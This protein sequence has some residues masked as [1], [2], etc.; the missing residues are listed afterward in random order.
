ML[1][2]FLDS[3]TY[4]VFLP[5]F[6]GLKWY[7]F[8]SPELKRILVFVVLA[9][10]TELFADLYQ[11]LWSPHTMPIGNV[12]IPLSMLVIGIFFVKV[13]DGYVPRILTIGLVF[14]YELFCVVNLLFFQ[15][16]NE[17]PDVTGSLGS[18]LMISFSILLFVK[19]MIDAKIEQLFQEPIVWINLG[20]LVYASASLFYF[21]LFNYSLK[22]SISFSFLT[23]R[24]HSFAYALFYIVIA[25]AFWK[26]RRR[27]KGE[28]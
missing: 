2:F 7:R 4:V 14:L 24:I 15:N 3:I 25:I 10:V 26:M 20:I 5:L 17:F 13:L 11:V 9:T 23:V 1:D 27:N 21:A 8:L 28:A 6:V 18:L 12:Y 19:I 22:I 16:I